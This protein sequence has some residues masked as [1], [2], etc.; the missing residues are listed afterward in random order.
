MMQFERER[1]AAHEKRKHEKEAARLRERLGGFGS[2]AQSEKQLMKNVLD[3]QIRELQRDVDRYRGER[4]EARGE[5]DRAR[6]DRDSARLMCGLQKFEIPRLERENRELKEQLKARDE[7]I[8]KLKEEKTASDE[9]EST[10]RN[11]ESKLEKKSEECEKAIRQADEQLSR[12]SQ[13][14]ES[15]QTQLT[16][17]RC[18]KEDLDTASTQIASLQQSV[19]ETEARAQTSVRDSEAYQSLLSKFNLV[20]TDLNAMTEKYRRLQG[21]LD[22]E[23]KGRAAEKSKL[24]R[25]N[26]NLKNQVKVLKENKKSEK[27]KE[28]EK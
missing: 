4:D 23:I 26:S 3:A 27:I 12:K 1:E 28:K 17:T 18:L 14:I 16:A 21:Q 22:G 5:R 9:V 13:E 10:L 25:D 6:N 11:V 15:L 20:K 8:L 2:R 7:A 24:E 19:A